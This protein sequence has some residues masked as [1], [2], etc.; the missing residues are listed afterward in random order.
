[1]VIFV[2]GAA[3]YVGKFFLRRFIA[4]P[5]I[6]KIVA[7]DAAGR[8]EGFDDPKI[9]WLKMN[10]AKDEWE[11]RVLK[12]GTP[13]A[14]FHFAFWI[15]CAYGK[16]AQTAWENSE[17]CSRV[18]D[19]CFKNKVK[20]V[21]YL[22]SAAVYGARRENI[23]RLFDENDA[24]LEEKYC[25]GI[26]KREV[27][28]LLK[29]KINETKPQ[30]QVFMIR[31][32]SISGPEG[33]KRKKFGLM[34]GLKKLLPVLPMVNRYWARQYIHEKDLGD[35]VELLA[36]GPI[37]ENFEIFNLASP[38]ILTM[39]DIAALLGKRT[40]FLPE[41]FIKI[42]F[43]FAWHLTLGR[44]PTAPGAE[45]SFIWPINMDGSKITKFGFKYNHSSKETFLGKE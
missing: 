25:Y 33:D 8:P 20:R 29:E 1:M 40:F 9:V 32:A 12:E 7:L 28:E 35:A 3:G 19:F 10:L 6:E 21:I 41:I 43:F 22:S 17:S 5:K 27:E 42:S 38:D 31:P 30:T 45:N 23:N 4:D 13:Q 24:I 14:V 26:Q 15:R 39:K 37:K 11:E 18:F 16:I 36:F 2:T 44:I 34:L